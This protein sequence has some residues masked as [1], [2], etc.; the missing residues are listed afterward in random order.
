MNQIQVMVSSHDRLDPDN[1]TDTDFTCRIYPPITG[2]T[3]VR[4]NQAVLP[5]LDTSFYVG[6]SKFRLFLP[7]GD[8]VG[9]DILKFPA[10]VF[11]NLKGTYYFDGGEFGNILDLVDALNVAFTNGVYEDVAEG[12]SSGRAPTIMFFKYDEEENRVKLFFTDMAF[13]SRTVHTTNPAYTAGTFVVELVDVNPYVAGPENV[14]HEDLWRLRA[15]HYLGYEFLMVNAEWEADYQAH[16]VGFLHAYESDIE[17]FM[18][19]I[20][21]PQSPK[22]ISSIDVAYICLQ[23]PDLD[24]AT[25]PISLGTGVLNKFKIIKRVR[26]DYDPQAATEVDDTEMDQIVWALSSR[27]GRVD[28]VKIAVIGYSATEDSWVYLSTKGK[29]VHIGLMFTTP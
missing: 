12:P 7:N 19:Y 2:A 29:S 21:A 16:Y 18:A 9:E 4:C 28:R 5:S 24:D 13:T 1:S 23:D 15:G 8:W 22:N 11:D 26:T 10:G 27:S 20:E 14:K 6:A 17:P 3:T 25:A